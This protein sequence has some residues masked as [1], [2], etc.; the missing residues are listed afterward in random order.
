MNTH[1]ELDTYINATTHSHKAKYLLIGKK[2]THRH[3]HIHVDT[4][5]HGKKPNNRKVETK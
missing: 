5:I 1:T 4:N 3:T 2:Y